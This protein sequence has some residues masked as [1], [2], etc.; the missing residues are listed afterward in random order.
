VRT[1]VYP[2]GRSITFHDF[3]ADGAGE[4]ACPAPFSRMEKELRPPG[5]H[6]SLNYPWR[7]VSRYW[8][9]L[10]ISRPVSMANRRSSFSVGYFWLIARFEH[11]F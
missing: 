9:T 6:G 5:S 7:A 3:A 8:Q 2:I 1:L 4:C 10:S 11:L